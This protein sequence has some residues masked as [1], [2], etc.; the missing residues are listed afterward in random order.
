[1][2]QLIA[3]RKLLYTSRDNNTPFPFTVGITA[4]REVATG[5]N[6]EALHDAMAA[7]EIVF[8]GLDAPPIEVRGADSLQAV[9]MACDID[10]YLRGLERQHGYEIF[11][12]DGSPYFD[13]SV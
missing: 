4:P 9:A 12:D 6:D 8:E 13:P 2:A 11:W 5:T 10:P 7:C 1:M 3:Q